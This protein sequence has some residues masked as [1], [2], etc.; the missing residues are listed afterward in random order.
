MGLRRGLQYWIGFSP[1]LT[2][3][4]NPGSIATG[5]SP[6]FV[7]ISKDGFSQTFISLAV[8]IPNR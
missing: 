1:G 5:F 7:W 6:W 8:L 4:S 2:K 3:R